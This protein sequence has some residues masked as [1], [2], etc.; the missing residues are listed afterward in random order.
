ML[1]F[2]TI[3]EIVYTRKLF[4]RRVRKR[5]DRIR[6][7]GSGEQPLMCVGMPLVTANFISFG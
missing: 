6:R 1:K 4:G 3:F 2:K 5:V 7:R